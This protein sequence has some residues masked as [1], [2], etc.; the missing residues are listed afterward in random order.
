MTRAVSN[1]LTGCF[2]FEK[3]CTTPLRLLADWGPNKESSRCRKSG[4]QFGA[5]GVWDARKYTHDAWC[6]SYHDAMQRGSTRGV[7]D[8]GVHMKQH[9]RHLQRNRMALLCSKLEPQR[10]LDHAAR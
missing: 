9:A 7:H 2:T 1:G 4:T 6:S 10:R 3:R 8:L 5:I